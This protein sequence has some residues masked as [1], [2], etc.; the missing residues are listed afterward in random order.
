MR[1]TIRSGAIIDVSFGPELQVIVRWGEGKGV[2]GTRAHS[3]RKLVRKAAAIAIAGVIAGLRADFP[4]RAGPH[5]WH[6][7]ASSKLE[8]IAFQPTTLGTFYC[9]LAS[10]NHDAGS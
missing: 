3:S 1:E 7:L 2:L 6:R 8:F 4:C 10:P 5:R 9:F